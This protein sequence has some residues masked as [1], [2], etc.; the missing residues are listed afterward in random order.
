MRIYL[1]TYLLLLTVASTA[2]RLPGK[3]ARVE[4]L[5]ELARDFDLKATTMR[6][7][8]LKR[9]EEEGVPL[10]LQMNDGSEATLKYFDE[11]GIPVY[12]LLFNIDAAETTNTDKLQ[13]GGDLGLD[14]TGEGITVGVWD[15]GRVRD[16]HPDLIG[17]VFNQ[18]DA[19]SSSSH[20]T[21]VTGTIIADGNEN[22]I[23]KG[24]ATN[25]DAIVYYFNN[26]NSEMA[27]E[28][29]NGMILSNHSY[30]IAAGWV[31]NGSWSWRGNSG[32]PEDYKFGYYSQGESRQIDQI[33]YN[34]PYYTIVW[35]AGNDR[36]DV[37]DD[38]KIGPPDGPWDCIGPEGTAKNNLVVGAISAI[39]N[40]YEGP[41]DVN[42][43]SFSSTGPVD[44][45]RI[46]PD[47]VG[48]GVGVFSTDLGGYGTKS[49]TSMSSP[50]VTGSIALLQELFQR[51][52]G[53]LMKSATVKSLLFHTANEAGPGPG[54]DY[55]FGWGLLN[56]EAAAKHILE[57]DSLNTIVLEDTLQDGEVFEYSFWSKK[58]EPIVATV[59]WT[60]PPGNPVS[61]QVD[62]AD[63]MLINDLD[64][65]IIDESGKEYEPWILDP[66]R[67]GRAATKGDNF[68]DNVEQVV[69]EL[70]E[71]R[72]YKLQINH[73]G[74]LVDGEQAFSLAFSATTENVTAPVLYWVGGSGNWEDVVH[75]SVESGGAG[76]AGLPTQETIV[77]FDENSFTAGDVLTLNQDQNIGSLRWFT[78][79]D[80]E[81]NLNG[82]QLSIGA[83]VYVSSHALKVLKQGSILLR[84]EMQ[85]NEVRLNSNDLSG[86]EIMLA[87]DS[88]WYVL[89]DTVRVR[90]ITHTEGFL[91]LSNTYIDSDSLISEGGSNRIL[92]ITGSAINNPA[93][94]SVSA[95]NRSVNAGGSFI[96]VGDSITPV[97]TTSQLDFNDFDF[98]GGVRVAKL[99]TLILGGSESQFKEVNVAGE[100]VVNSDNAIESYLM[101]PGSVLRIKDG[102][103]LSL[104]QNTLV[105]GNQDDVVS[106]ISDGKGFINI[107]GH[108]KLCLDY[109]NVKGI[110]VIGEQA[111][112]TAGLNSTLDDAQNWQS[113]ACDEVLFA[114]FQLEYPCVNALS[115]LV[116]IST[117]EII[118]RQWAI[119]LS[120]DSVVVNDIAPKYSFTEAGNYRIRLNVA[121]SKAS[122]SVIKEVA[123]VSNTLKK[124][125]VVQN[126]QGLVSSVAG[127][128]Y[129]WISNGEEIEGATNRVYELQ[130]AGPDRNFQVLVY[131][132]K[133]NS[134]SEAFLVV[135]VEEELVQEQI[136]LYPNPTERFLN[137]EIS[138]GAHRSMVFKVFD[139]QGRLVLSTDIESL[140][141]GNVF[142]FDLKSIDPGVYLI[143]VDDSDS[144][145]LRQRIILR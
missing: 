88:R 127:T 112:V 97:Q 18:P 119:D 80:S 68:R 99:S 122:N 87:T 6:A 116:D 54:P 58:N 102:V 48:M 123:I 57:I 32:D 141:S 108:V 111:A 66:E 93:Y 76:G 74:A 39:A 85:E 131:D 16:D 79:V 21:H 28:A 31:F 72:K 101:V 125:V 50:N 40:G 84:G 65:R 10:S 70:P 89:D 37:G 82:Q 107:D 51:E 126:P 27:N 20:A 118:D 128:F 100:L 35:A 95:S 135:A 41:D 46:K 19:T 45:G 63:L 17:R 13:V 4:V 12:T 130:N 129:Q 56:A 49:G 113:V 5:Q 47:I 96:M 34:A 86:A 139:I 106:I 38:P 121:N 33:A 104:S 134:L 136:K 62:A 110:D 60:D 105:K 22:A 11:Y 69:L 14:L 137:L 23:A 44:D 142:Q 143:S 24:M 26:D 92:D 94:L 55:R 36:N 75:W 42:I 91:D 145:L 71:G 109:L 103:T 52:H 30:G 67:P 140:E 73:K 138:G 124:P 98:P 1:L 64:M 81:I 59:A 120:G 3:F 77:V 144:N 29:A 61:P 117:G 15:G 83:S 115:D 25:A 132:D 7:E 8:A 9:A 114:D 90:K 53:Q 133:C 43:S 2:Q 78:K